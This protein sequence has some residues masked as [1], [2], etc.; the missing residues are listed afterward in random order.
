MDTAAARHAGARILGEIEEESLEEL[1]A[2]L[3]AMLVTSTSTTAAHT[4]AHGPLLQPPIPIPQLSSLI[5]RHHHASQSAPPPLLSLSGRHL[6]F[7]YHLVSTLLAAPHCY[8]VVVVDADHRFDVTR[9]VSSVPPPPSSS[10]AG[11]LEQHRQQRDPNHP[12]QVDDLRHLY[13]YR[14]ARSA[15]RQAR[16]GGGGG[17]GGNQVQ[18]CVAAAQQHLLYGRHASRG[19]TWW[20]TVVIGGGGGDVSAGWRGWME[21]QRREVPGFGVGT[22]AEEALAERE[23]RHAR[24]AERVWEGRS[25][26]GVYAWAEGGGA[27]GG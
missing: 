25:R 8:A 20:G 22:S 21:V 6:P 12:A 24:V 3:R 7:L 15:P 26:V 9:L 23:R 27:G 11:D 13:V 5:A 2:S 10:S 17:G 18:A 16:G 4:G 19:R 1:L 14:P